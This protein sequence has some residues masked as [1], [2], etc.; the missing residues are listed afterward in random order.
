[1]STVEHAVSQLRRALG[2]DAAAPRYIQTVAGGYRLVA[3]VREIQSAA[4]SPEGD[5]KAT[6]A[7]DGVGIAEKTP[8]PVVGRRQSSAG[9]I[10]Y[11]L[12]AAVLLGIVIAAT[13]FFRGSGSPERI[14]MAGAALSA[15]DG[16]GRMLWEHHF[17][18]PTRSLTEAEQKWRVRFVD[19]DGDG[20][21][22]VVVAPVFPEGKDSE[23]DE[24]YCFAS[25]GKLLWKYRPDHMLKFVGKS[26]GGPWVFL[27]IVVVPEGKRKAVW[28]SI[29]DRILVALPACQ[30][31][32]H[33]ESKDSLCELRLDPCVACRGEPR[34]RFR[35][36]RRPEQRVRQSIVGSSEG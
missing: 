11:L 19:L 13:S 29:G 36:G 8:Q 2:D 4:A 24:L 20:R 28:L 10:Y 32:S 26:F 12:G 34:R 5:P 25:N 31:R 15:W 27:D 18:E 1:M 17:D 23:R 6:P 14:T 33:R 21:R 30:H 7:T 16:K 35:I 3:E 9:R 22:E